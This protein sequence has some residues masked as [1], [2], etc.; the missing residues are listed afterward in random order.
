MRTFSRTQIVTT[1]L[2]F[3]LLATSIGVL[4]TI[5]R[6]RQEATLEE[7][8]YIPSS[9]AVKAMS[10][11]YTGLMAD[12]Y[13]T[14]VVQYFG[15]KHHAQS[16]QYQLLAPLL[17]ITTT[18]DPHLIPA[19]EFGAIF[20]EQDP[21]QGAGD[22]EAAAQLVEKGIRENPAAWRLWYSLGFVYWQGLHDTKKASDAFLQGS[23]VP[24]ALPWMG[25][26][27]AALAQNAGEAETARY[28]WTNILQTSNDSLIKKNAILRLKCLDSDQI[29]QLV[30]QRVD[31]YRD[32]TGATPRNWNDL[33][34]AGYLRRVPV[35]PA[36][37]PL[38]LRD[39]MVQVQSVKDLPFIT[40]GL[41]PGVKPSITKPI[42]P[43]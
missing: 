17:D 28:L 6:S 8:L 34:A 12:L 2:T 1:I 4:I 23:K 31:R 18:L 13:W 10:L 5:N 11:G 40:K 32:T 9:S 29:V 22:P 26:M 24:G 25:V 15:G 7:V 21:P 19:Y 38:V 36:E 42:P 16:T 30:Q 35:D 20:L 37:N 41:P 39:G 43:K 33:I 3:S 14:R 27:A